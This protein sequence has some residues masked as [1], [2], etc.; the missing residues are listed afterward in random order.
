MGE[1]EGGEGQ[2]LFSE[3]S[4]LLNRSNIKLLFLE[5]EIYKP[6]Y[7]VKVVC[8]EASNWRDRVGA[9]TISQGWGDLHHVC[10]EEAGREDW[11]A[12]SFWK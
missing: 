7:F 3:F 10:P 9:S 8:E 1:G 4:L 5:L 6:S 2:D 11:E 12:S